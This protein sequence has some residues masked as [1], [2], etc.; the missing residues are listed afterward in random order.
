MSGAATVLTLKRASNS[1]L[2][3]E[4]WGPQINATLQKPHEPESY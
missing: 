2:S 4:W 3:G 1:R